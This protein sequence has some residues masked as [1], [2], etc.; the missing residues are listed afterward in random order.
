MNRLPWVLVLLA[1]LLAVAFSLAAQYQLCSSCSETGNYRLAGLPFGWVGVGWFSL[2]IALW[3]T[4]ARWGWSW[5]FFPLLL[6]AT[7]GAEVHF[8]WIQK[9]QIGQWCPL[10]LSIAGC[11]LVACAAAVWD[12]SRRQPIEGVVMKIRT[13]LTVALFFALGLTGSLFAVSKK[14]QA[15]E[16]DLFLGKTGSLTTVY[17]VSDWFCPVCRKMEPE[18]ERMIPNL[19][20]YARLGFVDLPIHR[21]T[22]NFTPYHL[23]FLAYEK[24][25]Y[26]AL[27]RALAQLALKTKQPAE[28]EVRGAVAPLG[29]KLRPIDYA[30]TFAA[31]QANLAVCRDYKIKATPSVVIT[32]S[33]RK[34]SKVLVGEKQ[35]SEA[36]IKAAIVEVEN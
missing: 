28:A 20:G 35:I 10:C 2:L 14:A 34:K 27:R 22:V 25:K 3:L 32:N 9:Y 30:D 11:V 13:L 4:R 33:K 7:A 29:V 24:Q 31:M 19:A 12:G 21:E 6:A 23:Q 15:A 36:A 8:T 5:R 18:I 26:P 16:A 1:L 17:V